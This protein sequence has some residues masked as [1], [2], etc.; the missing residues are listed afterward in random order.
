MYKRITLFS[1]VTFLF[2]FFGMKNVN[3]QCTIYGKFLPDSTFVNTPKPVSFTNGLFTISDGSTTK[4]TPDTVIIL[5]TDPNGSL[6]N[7]TDSGSLFVPTTDSIALYYASVLGCVFC[8]DSNRYICDTAEVAIQII[9]PTPNAINDSMTA[10]NDLAGQFFNVVANDQSVTQIGQTLSIIKAPHYGSA[11]IISGQV[12]YTPNG[13]G[14]ADTLIYSL[15]SNCGRCDTATVFFEL[16]PCSNP[17]V[18]GDT[19]SVVQLSSVQINIAQNDTSGS[20]FGG[21]QFSAVT[22][23]AKGTIAYGS[24]GIATYTPNN[25]SAGLDSFFYKACNA[26]G[27]DTGLIVVNVSAVPCAPPTANIDNFLIG[28]TA[29]CNNSLNVIYNDINPINSGN[30]TLTI[31]QNPAF[32]VLTVNGTSLSYHLTSDTT[33]GATT[34]FLYSISNNCGADTALATIQVTNYPCNG[35]NPNILPDYASLCRND[36]VCIPVT[37]NDFDLDGQLVYLSDSNGNSVV[38]A[39]LHGRVVKSDSLTLCYIPDLNYYG[40][41]SFVYIAGDNGT[42]RLYNINKVYV[43]VNQCNAPPVILVNGNPED[44]IRITY[45]EDSMYVY[46]LDYFEPNGDQVFASKTT[47]STQ[48]S[49]FSSPNPSDAPCDTIRAPLNWVG[50]EG[51]YVKICNEYPT[52]DSIWVIA[53]VLPRED[54]PVAVNDTVSVVDETCKNVLSND[55]DVDLGDHLTITSADTI[56]TANGYAVLNGDSNYCYYPNSG[57]L[58][59]DTFNYVICDTTNVCD[60]ATVFLNVGVNAR[61]DVR[62]TPQEQTITVDV[63]TND[64]RSTY[65]EVTICSNPQHGAVTVVNNEIV[66]T[67]ADNYPYDPMGTNTI[68][69]GQDSFCYRLCEVVNGDTLCDVAMVYITIIPKPQF[70]I[71]EGF[72]PN[73]D[74]YNQNFVIVS[75]DEFPKSQLLVYNR[76]GDEVWRNV[77]EGYKNDF[78]GTFRKNGAPLPDGSYWY[79]FKFNDG[80]N[81]DRIGYIVIQR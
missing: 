18:V 81:K 34:S 12:K 47:P 22:N 76:Y 32:G 43:T 42:P 29:A 46:C 5:N 26:C 15:C 78:D 27:C 68:G 48:T 44:T 53:T 36:T 25:L 38:G 31:L 6:T 4:V 62:T 72:S 56:Y 50:Q 24:N 71:P 45:Y 70:S 41:D 21:L 79:I 8:V 67:P 23:P 9:C 66:Y 51:F 77:E 39:P 7:V 37:Q 58:G 55:Y 52:C 59:L 10:Y 54:A 74:G 2:M 30:L 73:G 33:A 28:N 65:E 14:T 13:T 1:L 40:M 16:L 69:N 19:A 20:T 35:R 3:A 49:T 57:F 64:T 60:T 63:L 17:I 11:S 80:I 75:A 61:N